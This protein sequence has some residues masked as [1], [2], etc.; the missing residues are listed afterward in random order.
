MLGRPS[1]LQKAGRPRLTQRVPQSRSLPW[2]ERAGTGTTS[3]R[4]CLGVAGGDGDGGHSGSTAESSTEPGPHQAPPVQTLQALRA[5]SSSQRR[6]LSRTPSSGFGIPQPQGYPGPASHPTWSIPRP[7]QAPDA[8][9]PVAMATPILAGLPWLPGPQPQPHPQ[10]GE[11]PAFRVL[12][13]CHHGGCRVGPG[14]AGASWGQEEG[15]WCAGIST[16][17]WYRGGTGSGTTRDLGGLVGMGSP[18]S[19][20]DGKHHSRFPDLA[21]SC[22]GFLRSVQPPWLRRAVLVGRQVGAKAL[23]C[24]CV[25]ATPTARSTCDHQPVPCCPLSTVPL[26]HRP[27]RCELPARRWRNLSAGLLSLHLPHRGYGS[28]RQQRASPAGSRLAVLNKH[29]HREKKAA[30]N[31]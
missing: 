29:S 12:R 26:K 11:D 19:I 4:G 1:W 6:G 2:A 14:N 15:W 18:R 28:A 25:L 21:P 31:K 17:P 16:S 8:A 10:R 27:T 13:G 23:W 5:R 30:R 3:H 9:P 24:G 20:T 22:S 7:K